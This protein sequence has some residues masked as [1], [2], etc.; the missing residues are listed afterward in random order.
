MLQ[1]SVIDTGIN[2]GRH[3]GGRSTLNVAGA[4]N[5][6]LDADWLTLDEIVYTGAL[7]GDITITLPVY[8]DL[9]GWSIRINNQ[10]T[11]LFVIST[12]APSG[13]G[14]SQPITIPQGR[15]E[16]LSW[17]G[18]TLESSQDGAVLHEQ[19]VITGITT[20]G[21]T[22]SNRQYKCGH[23]T[24]QG[25]PGGAF[26]VIVRQ[27]PALFVFDNETDGI[28]TIKT[29]AGTGIA[30]GVGKAAMVRS[31]LVNVRRVTADVDP[32]V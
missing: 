11:G 16:I 4:A 20:A 14:A 27:S 17:N 18:V 3:R 24:L 13:V 30:I 2:R 5:I 7:T 10:S 25:T 9:A 26:N 6:S 23:I 22:L 1:S 32:T 29:A 31:D 28:A 8:A 21:V 15:R 12:A 19:A